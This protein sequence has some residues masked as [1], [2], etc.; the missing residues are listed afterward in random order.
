MGNEWYP[1]K[2]IFYQ[3]WQGDRRLVLLPR[4]NRY[5]SKLRK[6]YVVYG[7]EDD[8]ISEDEEKHEHEETGEVS[9][10]NVL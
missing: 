4:K 3:V 6:Y 2:L 7:E 5:N 10:H 9:W 8:D 1:T